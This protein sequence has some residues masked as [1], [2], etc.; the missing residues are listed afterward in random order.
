LGLAA[1]AAGALNFSRVFGGDHRAVTNHPR[2]SGFSAETQ[3][4]FDR[5]FTPPDASRAALYGDLID[6]LVSAGIWDL[7]DCLYV[8]AAVDHLTALTN[9]IP[10]A[11][12]AIW[13]VQIGNFASDK[14]VTPLGTPNYLDTGFN[15]SQAAHFAQNSASLFAWNLSFVFQPGYL[16]GSVENHIS[17]SDRY[18]QDHTLW[19][20]N[21]ATD[22]DGGF[23]APDPSGFWLTSRTDATTSFLSR[24]GAQLAASSVRAIHPGTTN[25]IAASN[26]TYQ[27]AAMGAGAGL[28]ADQS[29]ALF[30]ALQ[31]YLQSIGAV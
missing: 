28:T 20:I 6:S 10:A 22:L 3:A 21:S 25:I 31:Q 2:P 1:A 17:P 14:G 12:D 24:N 8:F 19:A 9:L 13:P 18:T 4:F 27:L 16:L 5:L 30:H 15:P 29:S 11:S 23:A 26:N 7:L